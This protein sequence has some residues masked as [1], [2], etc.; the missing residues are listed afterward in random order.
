MAGERKM[1]SPDDRAMAIATGP[2]VH[3]SLPPAMAV[4][5]SGVNG[6]EVLD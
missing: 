1:S 3:N 6:F 2:A 4:P 5:D